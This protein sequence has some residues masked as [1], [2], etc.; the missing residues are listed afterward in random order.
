MGQ[1]LINA[2]CEVTPVV[3]DFEYT[4]PRRHPPEPIE[5]AVQALH[6]R[7]G[8]LERTARWGG[9]DAPA[10]TRRADDL[11]HQPDRHHFGHAG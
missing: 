5:V 7:D 6:V 10:P 3:I 1:R 11:R 4:T 2:L 9:A 8:K